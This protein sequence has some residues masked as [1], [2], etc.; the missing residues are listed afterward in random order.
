MRL[1]LTCWNYDR[2]SGLLDGRVSLPGVEL[3]CDVQ[4]PTKIFEKAFTEAPYD[5]S[6][7]SASS[8]VMH[9]AQGTCPYIALPA[10]EA[11]KSKSS[12]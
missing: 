7:L 10:F 8:Y 2:V 12:D 5:I 3:K 1:T 4:Y 11:F 6:E 9:A